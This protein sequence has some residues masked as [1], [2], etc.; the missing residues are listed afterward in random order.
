VLADGTYAKINPAPVVST[1]FTDTSI[2]SGQMYT[3]VIT[4]VDAD[5]VES[6]YSDPVVATIP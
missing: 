2:Q 3:Y 1:E 4:A 5:N 6:D